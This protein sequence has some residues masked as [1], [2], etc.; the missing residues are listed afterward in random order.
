MIGA[1]GEAVQ[2]PRVRS[3]SP[4]PASSVTSDPYL[5]F[6]RK[7]KQELP[8]FAFRQDILDAVRAN[9]ILVM[10]GETGSGA[11]ARDTHCSRAHARPQGGWRPSS[12]FRGTV[13][14]SQFHD[15]ARQDNAGAAV[16]VRGWLL[17]DWVDGR[18][19]TAEARCRCVCCQAC[20]R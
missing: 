14:I 7:Q 18:R 1:N 17:Q 16:H 19:D 9:Q 6:I 11:Y 3:V 15:V 4:S 5:A 2:K 12:G 10:V 20:G 8:S 13:S